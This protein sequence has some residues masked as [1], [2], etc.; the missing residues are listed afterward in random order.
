VLYSLTNNLETLVNSASSVGDKWYFE[1]DCSSDCLLICAGDS[2]TWGDNLGVSRLED[3]YGSQMAKKLGWDFVNI[4]LPGESNL[5]IIDF[6]RKVLANLKKSYKEIKL[7]F[8]LTESSRDLAL[9]NY[10]DNKF[11]IKTQDTHIFPSQFKGSH[12]WDV[13]NLHARLKPCTNLCD[14][15]SAI[16]QA[17]FDTMK[18]NFPA[19]KN[20]K[21][22]YT[23]N[24]CHWHT[25]V[26]G[27]KN[28]MIWT[29]V[30]ADKG[31]L[32]KYPCPVVFMARQVPIQRYQHFIKKKISKIEDYKT[33]LMPH[34]EITEHAYEWLASSPYN[35]IK[36]TKHPNAQAHLWWA[37][38]LLDLT[39]E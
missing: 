39:A 31:K 27:N 26:F 23:K 17:T 28:Q 4:G 37:E 16:E 1:K 6:A 2:W 8:T 3:I 25:N 5:A 7:I 29:E 34:I 33:E 38:H 22:Y 12:T 24:F 9:V 32:Q 30:I 10:S 35:N 18:H 11:N 20:L 19:Q 13:I 36:A 14:V 15:M 21:I